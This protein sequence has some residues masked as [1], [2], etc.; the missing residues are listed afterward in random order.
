MIA[1]NRTQTEITIYFQKYKAIYPIQVSE[2]LGI[3]MLKA[4]KYFKECRKE[5]RKIS[6]EFLHAVDTDFFL[7]WYKQK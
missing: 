1:R 4:E 3:G 7:N 5:Y 6:K 2:G